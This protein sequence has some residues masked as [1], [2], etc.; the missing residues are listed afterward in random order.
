MP[1]FLGNVWCEGGNEHCERLKYC[2]FVALESC[3]VVGT[4]HESA[5]AGVEREA[6]DVFG[7]LLYGLVEHLEFCLGRFFVA[8]A[9]GVAVVVIETPELLEEAEHTLNTF[10][11]PRLGLFDRTEEHLVHAQGVSAISGYKV[12]GVLDVIH[13]LRHLFYLPATDIF[14]IL[15]L[16]LG[17]FELGTPLTEAFD[18]EYII[19][20]YVDIDMDRHNAV[21]IFYQSFR[22]EQFVV[23]L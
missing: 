3:Q 2:T 20:N 10:G 23:V 19:V 4:D 21:H 7:N 1:Q 14:A 17:I 16:K 11:V 8:D 18:V 22:Y 13:R 5:D 6:F 15:Q 9:E 12:V